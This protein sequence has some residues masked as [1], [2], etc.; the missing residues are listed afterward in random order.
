MNENL[1]V[2]NSIDKVR[3]R[4]LLTLENIKFQKN[5]AFWDDIEKIEHCI[6]ALENIEIKLL[7]T[8]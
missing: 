8:I 5:V 4:L 7:K 2:E 6:K 1:L 3:Q